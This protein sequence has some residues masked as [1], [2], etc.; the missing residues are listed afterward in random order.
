MIN[1]QFRSIAIQ[2][3][4]SV[5]FILCSA[6]YFLTCHSDGE[7][8]HGLFVASENTNINTR[9]FIRYV[10]DFHDSATDLNAGRGQNPGSFLVPVEAHARAGTDVTAQLENIAR[11][12]Q[13][14]L[15][16]VFTQLFQ[17]IC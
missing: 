13:K 2:T 10:R 5:N 12:Q 15:C 7:V 8:S 17:N 6:I 11:L 14:M 1:I 16:C 9:I 4:C 3:P